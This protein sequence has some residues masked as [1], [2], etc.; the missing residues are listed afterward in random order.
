MRRCN[1]VSRSDRTAAWHVTA[2][3]WP[4]LPFLLFL[5]FA[6]CN[7]AR[8]AASNA[9]SSSGG[10]GAAR[11]RPPSLRLLP[12]PLEIPA[13]PFAPPYRAARDS[14]KASRPFSRS[15]IR[16]TSAASSELLPP[17][18]PSS[19]A[20]SSAS[21]A[22]RA[23]FLC[24]A[25]RLLLGSRTKAPN[26]GSFPIEMSSCSFSRKRT[27]SSTDANSMWSSTR[28]ISPF[29]SR[30]SRI[31]SASSSAEPRYSTAIL[32]NFSVDTRS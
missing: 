32:S 22:S 13:P 21:A 1:A 25:A 2:S 7:M 19:W 17:A 6:R 26:T 11:E 15:A 24:R 3:R 9:S 5:S 20:C 30:Y 18:S 16:A 31:R 4:H 8:C 23:A 14:T 10:G 27:S 29:A 28:P 12:M